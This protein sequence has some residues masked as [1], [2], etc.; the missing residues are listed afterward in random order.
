[1]SIRK[2][3][4]HFV[5]IVS[6]NEILEKTNIKRSTLYRVKNEEIY[7]IEVIEELFRVYPNMNPHY[8][9]LGKG[10]MFLDSYKLDESNILN[11]TNEEET[12]YQTTD[13]GLIEQIQYDIKTLQKEVSNLKVII[14]Q[15]KT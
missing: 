12:E 3:I 6:I 8:F 2:K 14:S 10:N 1:M 5:E 11:G 7:S 15:F 13:K 9:F 4:A